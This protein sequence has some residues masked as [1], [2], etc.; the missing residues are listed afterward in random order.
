MS[1]AE[2]AKDLLLGKK[3]LTCSQT[4]YGLKFM[5]RSSTKRKDRKFFNTLY[6]YLTLGLSITERRKRIFKFDFPSDNS[7]FIMMEIRF[8][9]SIDCRTAFSKYNSYKKLLSGE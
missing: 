2:I 4:D 3:S 5:M 6:K 7:N 8:P 1:N 9:R